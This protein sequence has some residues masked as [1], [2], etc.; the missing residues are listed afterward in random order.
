M[1]STEPKY[2]LL[3]PA[4]TSPHPPP[5]RPRPWLHALLLAT[6]TIL[7]SLT[8]TLLTLHLHPRGPAP[9]PPTNTTFRPSL[10]TCGS[11]PT[12]ARAAGCIFDP[13]SFAWQAPACHDAALTAEFMAAGN[14]TWTYDVFGARPVARAEVL[15]GEMPALYV[16][17]RFYVAHCVFMWRKMH[18]GVLRGVMDT[19]VGEERHTDACARFLLGEEGRTADGG[20]VPVAAMLKFAGCERVG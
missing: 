3:P 1:S 16:T 18:R 6:T 9:P 13:L 10:G 17:R 4:D 2:H 19:Y 14:W 7:L 15:A 20:E 11:S 5:H 8:T 12:A